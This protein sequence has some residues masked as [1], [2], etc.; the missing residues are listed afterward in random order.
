MPAKHFL[1]ATASFSSGPLPHVLTPREKTMPGFLCQLC[2][3]NQRWY[4]SFW[5][6]VNAL[7]Q[8]QHPLCAPWSSWQGHKFPI[9]PTLLHLAI[10]PTSA[11]SIWAVFC[12]PNLMD[13]LQGSVYNLALRTGD[14]GRAQGAFFP[15]LQLTEPSESVSG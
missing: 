2:G 12:R 13:L 14:I 4:R 7:G 11:A 3:N 1:R 6:P 5:M 10:C 9:I 15:V 8:S